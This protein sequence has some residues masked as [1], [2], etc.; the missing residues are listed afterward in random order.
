[1]STALQ[2][3]ERTTIT[4]SALRH[5]RQQGK[6]P[7]VVYGK[8]LAAPVSVALDAKD[9]A[10]LLRTNPHSILEMNVPGRGSQPV[11]LT[12]I[13]RDSLSGQVLHVDFHQVNLNEKIQA[14]VRLDFQGKSPGEQ[15][16]GMLQIV[17]H[18]LEVE[19]L[20]RDLPPSIPVDISLLEVGD[21]LTVADLKLPDGIKAAL[22]MD[23]VVASVLAPQKDRTEEELEAMD[24][25][26]EENEQH[27]RAFEAVEKD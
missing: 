8:G 16:G 18:E 5:L 11:L 2:A 9:L 23:T 20:A 19:C 26:A 22:E 21:H 7:G 12:D 25:A 1:M 13:Q 14:E 27:R 6:V 4:K 17:L 15:E 10:L 24:D 3:Q